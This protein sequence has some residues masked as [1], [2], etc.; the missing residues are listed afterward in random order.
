MTNETPYNQ[1]VTVPASGTQTESIRES[2]DL[3]AASDFNLT[4]PSLPSTLP[5]ALDRL[6]VEIARRIHAEDALRDTEARFRQLSQHAGKFLWLSDPATDQLLYVSPGYEQIWARTRE[7]KYASPQEWRANFHK[8][9][10]GA[11]KNDRTRKKDEVYQVADPDG[12]ACWVRDR[13]FPLRD[14]SGQIVQMLG[15]A[16]DITDAKEAQDALVA[17]QAKCRAL[18]TALPDLMFRLKK[19][20]TIIEFTAGTDPSLLRPDAKLV[21]RNIKE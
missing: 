9:A 12:A 11:G 1:N 4:S 13:M 6:D 20:G 7:S 10:E 15:I 14:S 2:Q 8:A 19:D 21:G 16:E 3:S 5:E 17:L 18:V